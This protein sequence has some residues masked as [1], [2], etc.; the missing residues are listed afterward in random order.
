M[1]RGG[2]RRGAPAA[3]DPELGRAGAVFPLPGVTLS[4]PAVA[5]PGGAAESR[6][7]H[8][9]LP[10]RRLIHRAAE[11]PPPVRAAG[12]PGGTAGGLRGAGETGGCREAGGE[13]KGSRGDAG[14]AAPGRAALTIPRRSLLWQRLPASPSRSPSTARSVAGVARNQRHPETLSMSAQRNC[15]SNASSERAET[16]WEN[17]I[18]LKAENSIIC[19]LFKVRN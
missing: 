15:N 19:W 5:W 8:P 3:P 6:C 14:P 17:G 18:G 13:G 1:A 16:A 9:A 10:E 2:A 7:P 12:L 4:G 11:G